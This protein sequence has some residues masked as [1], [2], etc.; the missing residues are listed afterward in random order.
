MVGL[1]P[2]MFRGKYLRHDPQHRCSTY[3]APIYQIHDLT[4]KSGQDGT[5]LY[6]H[7]GSRA[8]CSHI[9]F[10]KTPQLSWPV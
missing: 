9:C 4:A 8:V 6:N 2:E 1:A 3:G 10:F 5:S 7:P